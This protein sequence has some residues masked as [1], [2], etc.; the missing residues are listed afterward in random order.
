MALDYRGLNDVT[1]LP[2]KYAAPLATGLGIV[3]VFG[4]DE[5]Y[6]NSTYATIR[7]FGGTIAWGAAMLVIAIL[8]WSAG[9]FSRRW[10]FWAYAIA[11]A[12]YLTFAAAMIDA[13]RQFPTAS[14]PAVVMYVWLFWVHATGAAQVG[15]GKL[16][17]WLFE[18]GEKVAGTHTGR[19]VIERCSVLAHGLSRGPSG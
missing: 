3:F 2:P 13:V 14:L 16:S 6:E 11:S 4:A 1:V 19:V 9:H 5:R 8:L 7:A 17:R 18:R 12:G 15:D 10:N